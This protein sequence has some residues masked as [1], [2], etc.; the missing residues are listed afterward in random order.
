MTLIERMIDHYYVDG[1]TDT[2]ALVVEAIC[3]I[4]DLEAQLERPVFTQDQR[5]WIRK[6]YDAL[7]AAGWHD[8][9]APQ[10]ETK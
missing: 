4:R 9:E 8:P 6:N 3:R 7:I 5:N 10:A 1:T 2:E